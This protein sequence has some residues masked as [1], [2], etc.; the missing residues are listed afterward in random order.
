M[1]DSNEE[2]LDINAGRAKSIEVVQATKSDPSVGSTHPTTPFTPRKG[3]PLLSLIVLM[4]LGAIGVIFYLLRHAF[5]AEFEG[6]GAALC[7]VACGGFLVRHFIHLLADED[8]LQ[9]Q[10]LNANQA[11]VLPPK[12]NPTKLQTNPAALPPGPHLPADRS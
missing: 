10:Q 8:K 3:W 4:P 7:A 5:A 11:M 6:I 9:D 12:P 2:Q 1:N